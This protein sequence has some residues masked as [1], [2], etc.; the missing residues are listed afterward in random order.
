M[1]DQIV[2]PEVKMPASVESLPQGCGSCLQKALVIPEVF[3]DRSQMP[4]DGGRVMLGVEFIDRN[5]QV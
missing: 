3:L 2:E 5:G 4:A 1:S